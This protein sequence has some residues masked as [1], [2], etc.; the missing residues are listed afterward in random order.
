MRL[1]K[2]A[3]LAVKGG[4]RQM[5]GKLSEA[6]G[7]KGPTIYQYIASNSENLTKAAA[8]EVILE[9]TGLSYE[10]LLERPTVTA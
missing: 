10:L 5:V 3:L 7:V 1:T 6:L 4:G 2:L 9:E 8:L